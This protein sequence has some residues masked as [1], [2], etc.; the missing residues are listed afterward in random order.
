VKPNRVFVPAR[1]FVEQAICPRWTA[2]RR[3]VAG[4]TS[5]LALLFAASVA[6]ADHWEPNA[7][8]TATWQDNAT[9]ANRAIDK[10]AAFQTT[11]DIIGNERYSL[12]RDDAAHLGFH[13]AGE[14]WP[15]YKDLMTGALGVRADW[16]HKFGLGALAPVFSVELA[17]DLVAAKETGRRGTST[18]VSVALRKRFNDLWK[19]SFTV[20]FNQMYARDAVYDRQGTQGTLE[21]GRDLTE[22]SRLTLAV[23]QRSGDIVSYATPPRPDIVPLAPNRLTT[24]TFRHSL[25][26]YSVDAKTIGAKISY[27]HALDESSAIV[28]AYECRKTD[29]DVL[30]YVNQL[31]SL[32]LVHQF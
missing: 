7:T 22:V 29:R 30:R 1:R 15:R 6:R 18:G 24:E 4:A 14:W 26:A 8:I 13:A 32:A 3:Q 25:V 12:T 5:V 27:I 16:E 21:V 31:V 2:F 17:G 19:A 10:I 28:A 9:N 11:A 20:D 23:F